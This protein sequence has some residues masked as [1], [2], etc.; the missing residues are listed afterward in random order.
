MLSQLADS[1]RDMTI[2]MLRRSATMTKTHIFITDG[3]E[4]KSDFIVLKSM[5]V[6]YGQ[7]DY[8]GKTIKV[9]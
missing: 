4:N 9:K 2:S 5:G 3:I 7:E 1:K 6:Q 8:L